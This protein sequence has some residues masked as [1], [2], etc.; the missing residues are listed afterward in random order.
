MA[1]GGPPT[2]SSPRARVSAPS[3]SPPSRASWRPSARPAAFTRSGTGWIGSPTSTSACPPRWER[4]DVTSP[5][6]AP[7]GKILVV[8]DNR[9]NRLLLGR[10]LEQLGHTVSFAE[11]GREAVE[12]LRTQRADLVLLDIEM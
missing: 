7:P 1:S 9:V 12:S 10:S 4:Y 8:D 11:N 6:S 2:R 3:P 5:L